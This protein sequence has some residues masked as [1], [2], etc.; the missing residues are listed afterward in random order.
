MRAVRTRIECICD[1]CF[2]RNNAL[3]YYRRMLIYYYDQVIPL[4][5]DAKN[6]LKTIFA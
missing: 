1:T 2:F 3:H 4:Q 6:L 5:G